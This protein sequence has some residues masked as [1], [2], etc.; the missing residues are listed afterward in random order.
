MACGGKD[1]PLSPDLKRKRHGNVD[2][3]DEIEE[4][5]L[6][7]NKK[8]IDPHTPTIYL[9]GEVD[10]KLAKSF[11]EAVKELEY[12]RK[13]DIA[14]IVID[15]PGGSLLACFEILNTMRASKIEFMTYCVSYAYSAA[16][17]I[18]SAGSHGKRFM[19]PLSNAMVHQLSAGTGG[20]L[21]EMRVDLNNFERMNTLFITEIAKNCGKTV[22]Q[23]QDA[24]SATGFTDLFL[25]PEEAKKLGLVDEVAYVSL[26][27]AKA[28][29]LE[30]ITDEEETP[31][32]EEKKPVRKKTPAKK[33]K[34]QEEEEEVLEEPIPKPKKKP[35]KKPSSK[36]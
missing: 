19:A 11:R 33:A 27:Q 8:I 21:E 6:E 5:L 16:A 14:L 9:S 36:K 30:I 3:D 28:Y 22:K 10:S 18:L 29:Q 26:I 13:A 7:T 24:I 25:G 17:C 12:I 35:V 1:E 34:P 32:V 15:S 20:H 31:K 23:I 4:M 2:E